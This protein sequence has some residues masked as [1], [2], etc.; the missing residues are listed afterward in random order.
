MR[1]LL[2]LFIA[3]TIAACSTSQPRVPPPSGTK[4]YSSQNTDIYV[5]GGV[6]ADFSTDL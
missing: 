3:L 5:S 6:R 2:C 1:L 4:V